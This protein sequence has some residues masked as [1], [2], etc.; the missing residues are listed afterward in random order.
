MQH[1]QRDIC[2]ASYA[3]PHPELQEKPE[4]SQQSKSKDHMG[5]RRIDVRQS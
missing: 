2:G 4:G 3:I 5:G 1:S